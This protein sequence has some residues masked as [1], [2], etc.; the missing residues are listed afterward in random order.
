MPPGRVRTLALG[1]GALVTTSAACGTD[2]SGVD[3]CRQ[4]EGARCKQ[5]PSCGI[6]LEPPY[7]TSTDDVSS[8]IRFYDLACLH[9]L[10]APDPG[11]IQLQGCVN[12][13]QSHGCAVVAA[14][15]SDPECAWLIP[16]T[17]P[18][19]SEAGTD[20][21]NDGVAPEAGE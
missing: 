2:A 19:P 21:A 11:P 10:E 3:A 5:A 8:C 18:P 9:G 4:V 14:P 20:S 7:H 1:L 17:P 13:I 6:S 15:Q 12:A 16:P